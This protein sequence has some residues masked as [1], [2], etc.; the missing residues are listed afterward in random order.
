MNR[1]LYIFC[2]LFILSCGEESAVAKTVVIKPPEII[3]EFDLD[4]I[5]IIKLE[6]DEDIFGM[7]LS[8]KYF[9]W[10]TLY[11]WAKAN[12]IHINKNDQ[13][14]IY[15]FQQYLGGY[16]KIDTLD[17]EEIMVKT[18]KVP[19]DTSFAI[20][21]NEIKWFTD[22][23]MS[24]PTRILI[25]SEIDLNN[26]KSIFL[27]LNSLRKHAS[28]LYIKK[29]NEKLIKSDELTSYN[30]WKELNYEEQF[31]ISSIVQDIKHMFDIN[32]MDRFVN[33]I[34]FPI[35]G[36]WSFIINEINME[37]FIDKNGFKKAIPLL[38]DEET[39][40]KFFSMKSNTFLIEK[41]SVNQIDG[42][43]VRVLINEQVDDFESYRIFKFVFEEGEI[44]L[45]GISHS[46]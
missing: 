15:N 8:E 21:P 12:G 28:A 22:K 31:I 10:N 3:T 19:L 11:S 2:F 24:V 39:R 35:E 16:K 41:D 45:N 42:F 7:Q 30:A 18:I 43:Q 6:N 14:E 9:K 37:K 23:M 4:E 1:F 40:G 34:Q 38:F 44:K 29:R 33:S 17:N 20:Q 46:G 36:N 26:S 5:Q 13:I 25:T 27:V 32:D